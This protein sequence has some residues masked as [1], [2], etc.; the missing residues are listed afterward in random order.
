M[1][2]CVN[3]KVSIILTSQLATKM[4]DADGKNAGFD[5]GSGAV[6]VPYLGSPSSYLSLTLGVNTREL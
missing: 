5:S 3:H 4:V 1:K 6:M 2:T